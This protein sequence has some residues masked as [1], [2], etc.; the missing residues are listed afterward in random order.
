MEAVV[1]GAAAHR[2]LE[3]Q[4]LAKQWLLTT[5]LLLPPL[6]LLLRAQGAGALPT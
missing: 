1:P 6:L 2:V 5:R 3:H 4:Q